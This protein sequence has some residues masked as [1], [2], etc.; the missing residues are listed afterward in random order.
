MQSWF[1][2]ER[3]SLTQCAKAVLKENLGLNRAVLAPFRLPQIAQ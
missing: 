3:A 2:T 1:D